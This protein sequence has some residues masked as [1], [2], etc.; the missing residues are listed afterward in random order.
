LSLGKQRL[1][2]SELQ[3]EFTDRNTPKRYPDVLTAAG[4]SQTSAFSCQVV[5]R[6]LLRNPDF[7]P[8]FHNGLR[9][10][11][12]L[13]RVGFVPSISTKATHPKRHRRRQPIAWLTLRIRRSYLI[14]DRLQYREH[15]RL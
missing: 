8:N 10:S 6:V 12:H 2:T 3:G 7:K 4:P 11:G 15:V 5:K 14:N 13:A 9:N 1:L